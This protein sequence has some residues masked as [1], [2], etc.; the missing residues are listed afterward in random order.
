MLYLL[1]A[2]S[3]FAHG[4]HT[5][6]NDL[7]ER[8][9]SV[10]IEKRSDTKVSQAV[11]DLKDIEVTETEKDSLAF[12]RIMSNTRNALSQEPSMRRES[13]ILHIARALK[14]VPYVA[15]TLEVG[16]HETLV[17][18][19]R[20][21]DCTTYVENVVAIYLCIKN[22]DYSYSAY[23]NHLRRLRY[24]TGKVSYTARLHYF[25]QWIEENSRMGIVKEIQSPTPPFT[26]SQSLDINFMSRHSDLYPRLKNNLKCI[27]EIKLVEKGLNGKVYKYIPKKDI[28][29]TMLFRNTIHDG[30]IIAITTSKQGLDM[31]HIGIAVWH[32]DGLHLLNASQIHKKVVEEPLLLRDYMQKHPSQVG[33]R[34]IRVC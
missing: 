2:M 26:S 10:S 31:S 3:L 22:K 19:L 14:G 33:I 9:S 29:N 15:Q 1:C 8:S 21:L 17:I 4:L 25:T 16:A 24:A 20:Q 32:K 18:N 13:L 12:E 27:N 5:I 7:H 28:A 34:I 30:D 6:Y 11:G 23:K